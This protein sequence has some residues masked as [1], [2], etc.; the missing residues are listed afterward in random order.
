MNKG[1]LNSNGDIISILNSDDI[2]FMIKSLVM[3]LRYLKWL[4]I[5]V[6]GNILM[7]SNKLKN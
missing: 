6:F 4:R 2:Y 1:I 3:L 7:Y 5:L